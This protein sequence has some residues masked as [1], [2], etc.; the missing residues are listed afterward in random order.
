[1]RIR[2]ENTKLKQQILNIE[3]EM[4]DLDEIMSIDEPTIIKRTRNVL[5][6]SSSSETA[7]PKTKKGNAVEETNSADEVSNLTLDDYRITRVNHQR[8][9]NSIFAAKN[10]KVVVYSY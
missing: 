9:I 7:Q 8:I 10:T 3:N 1:M 5:S 4:N 6:D 2:E